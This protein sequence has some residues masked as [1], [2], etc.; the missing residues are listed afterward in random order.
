MSWSWLFAVNVPIGI[1]TLALSMRLLPRTEPSGH[2]FDLWSAVLC[3]QYF[4]ANSRARVIGSFPGFLRG[5]PW[6]SI[7]RGLS[8]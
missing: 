2:R 1:I 8:R 5:W 6:G 3:G 4:P 7:R